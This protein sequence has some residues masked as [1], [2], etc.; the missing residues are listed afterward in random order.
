MKQPRYVQ[1]LDSTDWLRLWLEEE[2]RLSGPL[3]DRTSRQAGSHSDLCENK[4]LLC[5]LSD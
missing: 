3:Y 2:L 5:D 4:A 1:V